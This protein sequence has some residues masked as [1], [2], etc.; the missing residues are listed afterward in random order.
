MKTWYVLQSNS[1]KEML[2]W[3][4]CHWRGIE[5]YCPLLRVQPVN[6]RARKI[7]PYFPGYLFVHMDLDKAD[8]AE[9]RW[10]AGAAGLVRFGD[11]AASIP[12]DLINAIKQRVNEINDHGGELWDSLK[13]GVPIRIRNGVFNGYQAIFDAR[14]SDHA[15]ARVL[16]ELLRGRQVRVELPITQIEPVKRS[17]A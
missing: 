15:R 11:I 1:Q 17:H 6:P 12:D 7:K 9:L 13:P 8:L 16:I 14:L 4:Q 2:V 5:A 3:E 10:M